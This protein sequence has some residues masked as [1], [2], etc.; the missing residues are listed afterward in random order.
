MFHQ[1]LASTGC[2]KFWVIT[3]FY[4]L[5]YSRET[6]PPPVGLSR[7][8]RCLTWKCIV[9]RNRADNGFMVLGFCFFLYI[10]V[11]K[12]FKSRL[13]WRREMV[14]AD[15]CLVLLAS[16]DIFLSPPTQN[17]VTWH[18]GLNQTGPLSYWPTTESDQELCG[19]LHES[20]LQRKQIK[21]HIGPRHDN[22]HLLY[23]MV[24]FKPLSI[25]HC[26][27]ITLTSPFT[28]WSNKPQQ[29]GTRW[30]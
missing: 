6:F 2:G 9:A 12:L 14:S 18:Q 17:C 5:V 20:K 13:V 4:G 7:G 22:H 28:W 24:T 23:H 21:S 11:I 25:M 27:T 8:R 16:S 3:L 30:K 15:V 29:M 26:I 19:L 10:N 1:C